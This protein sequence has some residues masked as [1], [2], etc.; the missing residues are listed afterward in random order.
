MELTLFESRLLIAIYKVITKLVI[1][2]VISNNLF[3]LNCLKV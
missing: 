1:L 3:T 2:N